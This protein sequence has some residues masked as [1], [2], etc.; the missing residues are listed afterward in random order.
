M[1]PR[2][3]LFV[4]ALQGVCGLRASAMEL[5]K[6]TII[7][8]GQIIQVDSEVVFDT[9]RRHPE[10]QTAWFLT[11]S[12]TSM[13]RNTPASSERFS[14]VADVVARAPG[15]MAGGG[16]DWVSEV[17]W[18]L[19]VAAPVVGERIRPFFSFDAMRS[20]RVVELDGITAAD[21]IVG[22]L[23]AEPGMVEAVTW[24]R[25]PIG[26]ETDTLSFAVETP[27]R[28]AVSLGAAGCWSLGAREHAELRIGAGGFLRLRPQAWEIQRLGRVEV[29]RPD[30]A[31]ETLVPASMASPFLSLAFTQGATTSSWRRR[32]GSNG[33]F[34]D[35]VGW[36]ID[37]RFWSG[38]WWGAVGICLKL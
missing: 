31:Q 25:Y 32:P 1:K 5:V 18:R 26:I 20:A 16:N 12:A 15:T 11:T 27:W 19:E 33:D 10:R 35:R 34:A 6:D 23:A 7:L 36:Q 30:A 14:G 3:I 28:F 2:F 21:S 38:G 24:E 29:P 8:D 17:G 37:A 4:V 9:L 22:W 13:W